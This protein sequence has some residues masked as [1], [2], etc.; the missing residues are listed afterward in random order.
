MVCISPR[1][2]AEKSAQQF[3]KQF[4]SWGSFTFCRFSDPTH[5]WSLWPLEYIHVEQ[6]DTNL[7]VH[8]VPKKAVWVRLL[9]VDVWFVLNEQILE[10]VFPASICW[11][12]HFK[13][14]NVASPAS[15]SATLTCYHCDSVAVVTC[16]AG[17]SAHYELTEWEWFQGAYRVH[18]SYS[19]WPWNDV[20]SWI[21]LALESNFIIVHYFSNERPPLWS[22]CQ[23]SW[24]Q[25]QRSGFD[26]RCYQIFWEI[27]GLKRGPLSLVSTNKALLRRK[28]SGSGLENREYGRRDPSRWPRC[29]L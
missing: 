21:I 4:C 9:A 6:V 27:V 29:T 25:I 5:M 7:L 18:M 19:F 1:A 15:H 12:S 17:A 23:S 2:C 14:R 20:V 24:L 11:F 3:E 8:L 28:S 10:Q 16:T 26:S 13:S 22:S